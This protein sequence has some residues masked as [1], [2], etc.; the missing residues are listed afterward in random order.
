[1]HALVIYFFVFFTLIVLRY[2]LHFV[3]RYTGLSP[4]TFLQRLVGIVCIFIFGVLDM[5]FLFLSLVSS[6]L[7]SLACAFITIV[8][9]WFPFRQAFH[10]RNAFLLFLSLYLFLFYLLRVDLV[11]ASVS[12]LFIL[13]VMISLKTRQNLLYAILLIGLIIDGFLVSSRVFT[14]QWIPRTA[15][16]AFMLVI[17]LLLISK[18]V[19][20]S[21]L[22][23]RGFAFTVWL[24]VNLFLAIS[25]MNLFHGPRKTEI[26]RIISQKGVKTILLYPE[27]GQGFHG[28]VIRFAF[29]SCDGKSLFLGSRYSWGKA[30]GLLRVSLPDLTIQDSSEDEQAGEM[31]HQDC[32]SKKLYFPVIGTQKTR[33]LV[34]S[35]N[36]LK[37][38]LQTFEPPNSRDITYVRV[39]SAHNRVY[40]VDDFGVFSVLRLSDGKLL[41]QRRE[42]GDI[43]PVLLPDGDLLFLSP[44]CEYKD[45]FTPLLSWRIC[46]YSRK[47]GQIKDMGPGAMR[48]FLEYDPNTHTAFV[49]EI[50][51]GSVR[52]VNL[53]TRRSTRR[54]YLEPFIWRLVF[55]PKARVL[56]VG[57]Y[58][59]GNLYLIDVDTGLILRKVHVGRQITW[60][61]VSRN[62]KGVYVATTQGVFFVEFP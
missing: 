18:Q 31:V 32:A 10:F 61:Y 55:A 45:S 62:G 34:L 29:E 2:V 25:F 43:S 33:V 40:V 47:N 11:E 8:S 50:F 51:N 54:I 23:Q 6:L 14:P 49:T 5:C 52:F 13:T 26:K 35:E 9:L 24:F 15:G 37:N 53:K 20:F 28:Q 59:K 21:Y 19:T 16:L 7:L 27:K 22:L 1:M 30:F 57:G 39:S 58:F 3:S 60:M 41:T 46:K 42:K 48:T 12:G 38:V 56:V 17:T 36:N 44:I 4:V